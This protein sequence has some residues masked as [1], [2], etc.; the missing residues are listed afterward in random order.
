MCSELSN[1]RRNLTSC[2]ISNARSKCSFT[3]RQTNEGDFSLI[4]GTSKVNMAVNRSFVTDFSKYEINP[5]REGLS[6]AT[7]FPYW[8]CLVLFLNCYS[9]NTRK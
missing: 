8:A 2:V 9:Y 5:S 3:F 7:S 1:T 4:L 6:I